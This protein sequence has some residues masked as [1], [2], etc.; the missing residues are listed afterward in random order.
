VPRL[1]TAVLLGV[2]VSAACS[3][4]VAPAS[5]DEGGP[6]DAATFGDAGNE[7]DAGRDAGGDAGQDAGSDAGTDGGLDGGSDAGHVP[8]C[9]AEMALIPGQPAC[10]DRW[11]G[12][13]L[14]ELPDGGLTPW[15]PYY[16]PGDIPVRAESS[17]GRQ[18]QGYISGT[19]AAAACARAGKRL[20]TLTEWLAACQGIAKRTYPYGTAYIAKACNEGRTPHPVVEFYGTSVGVW[21][22]VHMNDAGINQQANTVANS[23]AYTQCVTPE[24]V[25]DLVGNLHE[26]VADGSFKGGYYVDAKINGD[27]CLYRT[28]AH[29]VSYHDYS[30]GFRC[31]GELR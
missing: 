5:G 16:N 21:D 13:L 7:V 9:P 14:E 3:G 8:G 29:A 31:C 18:P 22:S 6:P 15:S 23:G 24:G 19:Q 26:W 2:L 25:A 28:T 17:A 1:V 11:E 27:G 20:C 12:A 30:T 10:I 4:G